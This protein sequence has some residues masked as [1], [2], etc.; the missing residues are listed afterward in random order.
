MQAVWLGHEMLL[1]ELHGEAC[2]RRWPGGGGG[3][4]PKPISFPDRAR[5][6]RGTFALL[7]GWRV[8]DGQRAKECQPPRTHP[9]RLPS[10]KPPTTS[11]AQPSATIVCSAL[12]SPTSTIRHVQLADT[13]R[14]TP[15]LLHGMSCSLSEHEGCS[16]SGVLAQRERPHLL[17]SL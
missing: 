17:G 3:V 5:R 16:A 6:R 13:G 1:Q 4:K 7:R 10:P 12:C 2:V 14:F 11:P 15:T 8:Q 9:R